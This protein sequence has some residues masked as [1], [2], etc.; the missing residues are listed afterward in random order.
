MSS[1]ASSIPQRSPL[2]SFGQLVHG[3]VTLFRA[4]A[5]AL[6]GYAGWLLLPL[7]AHVVIR[8]TF[9]ATQVAD[10]ADAVVEGAAVVVTL[11]IMT[12]IALSTPLYLAKPG[13]AADR[14]AD[15]EYVRAA[16]K[17]L[18][19][20]VFFAYLLAGVA[21]LFGAV[22]L[23]VPGII[24]SV[25]FAFAGLA[26]TFD[27]ARGLNALYA[28]KQ[29]VRGRFW[30]V[31]GRLLGFK[32]VLLAIYVAIGGVI[33]AAFGYA[34]TGEA[35]LAPP[36]LGAEILLSVLQAVLLPVVVLF[37]TLLYLALKNE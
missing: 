24:F 23:V 19:A 10:I 17:Q 8:V 9:G 6:L 33:L 28:S 34:P 37:H 31:F 18:L 14:A 26:A 13:S 11:L 4:N 3:T 15:L 32:L 25:W 2:P 22:L 7:A 5:G 29:L 1:K 20:P 16:A 36:P 21:V 30:P 12:T 27:G 35:A